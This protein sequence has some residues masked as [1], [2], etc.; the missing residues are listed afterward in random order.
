MVSKSIIGAVSASLALASFNVNAVDYNCSYNGG[1][2]S[3]TDTTAWSSCNGTYP[4][5]TGGS[6]YGAYV[7]SGS[8]NLNQLITLDKEDNVNKSVDSNRMI[9]RR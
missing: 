9:L 1:T 2:N 8:L 6:T 4:N 7:S 5:N 3:W